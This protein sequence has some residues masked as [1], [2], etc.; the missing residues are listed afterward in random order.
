MAKLAALT[1]ALT[2]YLLPFLELVLSFFFRFYK[3]HH[4]HHD[5]KKRNSQLYQND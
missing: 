3:E 5:N 2:K 1:N 4:R